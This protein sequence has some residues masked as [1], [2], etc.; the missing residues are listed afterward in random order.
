MNSSDPP[1]LERGF[2]VAEI[3]HALG[4]SPQFVRDTIHSG[5][6]KAY[7]IGVELRV[8]QKDFEAYLEAHISSGPDQARDPLR[9]HRRASSSAPKR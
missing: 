3:A 7:R 8:L 5:A 9:K 6:L 1:R 4:K 2:T